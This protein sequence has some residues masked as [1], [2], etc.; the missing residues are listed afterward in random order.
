MNTET[1]HLKKDNADSSGVVH[2]IGMGVS[3]GAC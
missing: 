3:V 1:E 2:L